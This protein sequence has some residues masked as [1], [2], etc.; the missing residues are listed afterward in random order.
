[1]MLDQE[2]DESYCAK[3]YERPTERVDTRA[4]YYEK[5]LRTKAGE[6]KLQIPMLRKLPFETAIFERYRRREASGG[7]AH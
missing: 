5:K 1:M 7:S 4:G 2:T 3:K 6:V